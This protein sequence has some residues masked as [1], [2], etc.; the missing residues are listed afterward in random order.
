MTIWKVPGPVLGC[1]HAFKYS[2]FYGYPGERVVGYDNER[3]K[4]DHRHI[5]DRQGRYASSSVET[6][7]ADFL[8]DVRHA[9]GE[10]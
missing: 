10:S 7:V 2:L 9:R 5:G 1:V 8:S 3:G 6:L 4:G